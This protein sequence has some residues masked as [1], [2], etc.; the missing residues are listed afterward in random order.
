MG[1]NWLRMAVAAA[2]AALGL[3][4]CGS[5]GGGSG[6]AP[7]SIQIWEGYTG[8]EAK[9]FAHLVREYNAQHSGTKVTSLFVN[10]DNSLEKVLTAVRG[11]SQPDIAYLYGS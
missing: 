9:T 5:S 10:N 4:A 8:V 2:L 11:G 3:A 6:A 1:R 7:G